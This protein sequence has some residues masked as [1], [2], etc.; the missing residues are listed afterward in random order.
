MK[1]MAR[2]RSQAASEEAPESSEKSRTLTR[3]RD[4]AQVA[5]TTGSGK[6]RK[7][8]TVMP[9]GRGPPQSLIIT[10]DPYFF[11]QILT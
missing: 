3:L 6:S 4:L 1:G 2:H 8:S 10:S 5:S 11:S 9:D 7:A